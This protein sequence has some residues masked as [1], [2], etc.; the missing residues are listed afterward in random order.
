MSFKHASR[1]I[2]SPRDIARGLTARVAEIIEI[3]GKVPRKC[4]W[5][6][7][8]CA[9][10]RAPVNAFT[11]EPY[12]GVNSLMFGLDP[13]AIVSADPRWRLSSRPPTSIAM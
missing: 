3:T 2:A 6:A 13:R 4:E 12:H 10:P 7:A 1:E 11:G 8:K 9:G 5:D